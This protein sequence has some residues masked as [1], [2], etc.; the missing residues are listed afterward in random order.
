M[1]YEFCSRWFCPAARVA[2]WVDPE[3]AAWLAEA[4]PEESR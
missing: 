3:T 4:I 2:V 1:P